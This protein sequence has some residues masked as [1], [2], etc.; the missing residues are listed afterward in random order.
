M[1]NEERIRAL[2]RFGYNPEEAAFL[3]LAALHSGYFLR[4]QYLFFVNGSKGWKDVNLLNKLSQNRHLAV[5]SYRPGSFVY[6][7]SAKPMYDALGERDNRNRRERQPATIKRKLMGLDFVL[8]HP[9][10]RYLATESEKA[11]FFVEECGIARS[12]LPARWYTSSKSAPPAVRYFV[13]KFPLYITESGNARQ[14]AHF[15]YVDEG[16]QSIDG[17]ATHLKQYQALLEGLSEFRFVYVSD[18]GGLWQSANRQFAKFRTERTRRRI[19]GGFPV[20]LVDYFAARRRYEARDY[21]GF[22][23]S[24]LIRLREQKAQFTGDHY[25]ELYRQWIGT[26]TNARASPITDHSVW[27][28]R[29]ESYTLNYHYDAI[30]P[31]STKK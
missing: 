20:E 15:S 29:F 27:R 3:V 30:A 1:T 9:G 5:D 7:L 22:D 4:R 18:S 26:A 11:A 16:S 25:D 13:D 31:L 2:M 21:S 24:A 8:E 10:Y 14:V 6:H 19:E 23:A 12:D 28:E 17:L